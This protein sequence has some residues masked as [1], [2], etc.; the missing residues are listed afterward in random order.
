VDWFIRPA[1]RRVLEKLR[2]ASVWPQAEARR[3][4]ELGDQPLSGL[5]FVI[6]GT[7][8]S[9]SRSDAKAYIESHGGKVTGS[10]SKKTDYLLLG[11]DPGSKL[12]KARGLGVPT[13]D[14]AGLHQLVDE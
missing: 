2:A 7:L 11:A 6:T 12:D 10:V 9:M 3:E 5:T 4:A 14:E 1:N 8:P 13:V